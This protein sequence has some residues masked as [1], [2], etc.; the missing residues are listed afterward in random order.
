LCLYAG[1]EFLFWAFFIPNSSWFDN[2]IAVSNLGSAL[3]D[4]LSFEHSYNKA[5]ST[6]I[7]AESDDI[8]NVIKHLKEIRKRYAPDCMYTLFQCPQGCVSLSTASEHTDVPHLILS[9]CPTCLK[10]WMVC[11]SCVDNRRVMKTDQDVRNHISKH[12]Q[13]YKKRGRNISI[14]IKFLI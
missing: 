10:Q 7:M 2:W 14:M 9:S 8:D 12:H 6:A 1:T 5:S 4:L 13:S 11:R 3:S